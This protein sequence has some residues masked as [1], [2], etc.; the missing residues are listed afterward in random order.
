MVAYVAPEDIER[1]EKEGRNDI[2]ARLQENDVVWAGDRLINRSG[3][4]VTTCFYLKWDGS[5]FSC[6][7]YETRPM[8]C[9]SFL[10]GSSEFCPLCHRGE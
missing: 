8:V 6:E 7:I 10:P 9:R 3:V 2:I 4:K 1:W 5:S